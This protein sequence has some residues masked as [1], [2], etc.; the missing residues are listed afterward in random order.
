MTKARDP[1]SARGAFA[2][3]IFS[4]GR[5]RSSGKEGI[6]R[7]SLITG[8]AVQTLY[9]A[10]NPEPDRDGRM[11]PV[12]IHAAE[13]IDEVHRAAGGGNPNFD[14]WAARLEAEH[15]QAEE[16]DPAVVLERAVADVRYALSAIEAGR[17]NLAEV[18]AKIAELQE[19]LGILFKAQLALPPPRPMGPKLVVREGGR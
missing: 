17:G 6:E 9:K 10:L 3:S 14:A 13:A 11:R 18:Q 8:L 5:D 1:Q 16:P 7:A 19:L 4:L 15:G 12:D 2:L